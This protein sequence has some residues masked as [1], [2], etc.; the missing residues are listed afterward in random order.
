[1]IGR[2]PRI[3]S[4]ALTVRS[5]TFLAALVAG[6]LPTR[7]PAQRILGGGS[8][9]VTLPRGAFRVGIG[10]ESTVQRDR[11]RDGT[12]EG[13]AG[14]VTADAFGPLQFAP[15]ISIQELV[16]GLGVSDFDAS[17]GSTRV[18]ARQRAFVT[19]LN[20]EYGLFD[21]L[22]LRAR[23]TLVR[24]RAESQF[25]IRTDSGRATLG[26]NPFYLGSAVP[27]S[28][29]TVVLAYAG[30]A[31]SLQ[32]R[33][34]DCL[35]NPGSAPECPTILAEGASVSNL[36]TRTSAFATLLSYLYGTS[37]EAGRAYVPLAGSRADSVLRT[38]GDSLRIA[39]ERYGVTNVTTLTGIPAAAGAPLAAADLDRLVTD[40]LFG[41]GA[42]GLKDASLTQIGDVHVSA[43]LRVH[44]S[45]SRAGRSRFAS[46]AAARGWRQAVLLEGRIGTS[47]RERADAFLDQGTGS[48]T[49]ALSI[50]S[51]TDVVFNDRF[52]TTFA[53]GYTKPFAKDVRVRVPSDPGNAWLE[54]EREALVPMSPGSEI[55]VEV[56][57]RWQLSDY[58]ALGAQWVWR[59][60]AADRHDLDLVF[61][62]LPA[63]GLRDGRTIFL[64]AALLDARTEADEQRFGLSATYSTLAARARGIPGL[65]FDVSYIHQQSVSS[66]R[67]VVPKQWEDRLM[68]RYYTRFFAR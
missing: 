55:D 63:I 50:R 54:W 21:W 12:L 20:I 53:V 37:T 18:D 22:T 60:K 35:A 26:V 43:L 24:T 36:L 38:I 6:F 5:L 7:L 30:A 67:G 8:D 13:L 3:P 1:M 59:N 27:G 40:S 49:S 31:G 48:G 57:P 16:R 23:A 47:S 42:R 52:W 17:L 32:T 41:Y 29:T 39:L 56:S 64:D 25:R 28:N 51:I 33:R 44:D 45:F 66:S 19:P 58:V 14:P 46:G 2:S 9:G 15:L 10:G 68:I 4:R 65:S 61:G 11:W 62:T 34:N